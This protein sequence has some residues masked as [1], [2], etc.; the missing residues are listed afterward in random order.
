M[1]ILEAKSVLPGRNC[2]MRKALAEAEALNEKL[3]KQM[4]E[5]LAACAEQTPVD[6]TDGGA[7]GRAGV[8]PPPTAG[9]TRMRTRRP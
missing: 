6:A 1:K 9:G 3:K 5:Q 2:L 8:D 7:A 4:Q